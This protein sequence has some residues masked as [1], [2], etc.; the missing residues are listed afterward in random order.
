MPEKSFTLNF[1]GYWREERISDLPDYSGIYCV[2]KCRHNS[3]ESTVAIRRL[4]YIG[5][6]DNVRKWIHN[7]P[8]WLMWHQFLKQDEQICISCAEIDPRFRKRVLAACV[9][10]HEPPANS[11]YRHDFPFDMTRVIIKGKSAFLD[12]AFVVSKSMQP[13][14]S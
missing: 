11:E 2:Y 10:K 14:R 12:S 4:L 5:E 13:H 8:M 9:R 7:H 1:D 6:A 3:S